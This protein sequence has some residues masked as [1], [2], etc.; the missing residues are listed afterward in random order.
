MNFYICS[1]VR[2]LLFSLLKALNENNETHKILFFSDFQ[3]T[4]L[5]AWDLSDLP[6][7]IQVYEGNR[8]QFRERLTNN[9]RG[10]IFYFLAMRNA[11]APAY[12]ETAFNDT[13]RELHPDIAQS[14][15]NARQRNLWLFNERNKMAR[16]FRLI[17]QD[18][19][20]IEE[21]SGNYH[22]F[23]KT[24]WRWPG[25]ALLGRPINKLSFG[26]DKRCRKILVSYPDKV[27]PYVR[28]KAQQIDF[29]DTPKSKKL[30]RKMFAG[31]IDFGIIAGSIVIA[32][33][34]LDEIDNISKLQ[35]LEFYKIMFETLSDMGMG[36]IL[37]LHPRENPQDYESLA[38]SIYIAPEKLP[39][40][41]IIMLSDEPVTIL[42]FFTSAGI[43]LEPYFNMVELCERSD[44][45]GYE[46]EKLFEWIDHPDR[47][48][49]L[50][51][52]RLDRRQ[53]TRN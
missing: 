16:V 44:S 46:I 8:R 41:I 21:G 10:K 1:T 13:L 43:G 29:L 19:C 32:T 25:R 47:L 6:N 50:I 52:S 30:V 17:N 7:N 34:P 23:K 2:H 39:L 49:E 14:F 3:N 27:P 5:D 26:E 22:Y 33:S 4:S 45:E 38:G 36:S 20:M 42:S 37:K 11:V 24:W 35:K 53:S 15:Q 18:F 28:H 31:T 51:K 12:F 9:L 40:E 48:K